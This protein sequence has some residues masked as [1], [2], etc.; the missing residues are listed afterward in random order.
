MC[1]ENKAPKRSLKMNPHIVSYKKTMMK[2]ARM[3]LPNWFSKGLIEGSK[4][5]ATKIIIILRQAKPTN[6]LF[7]ELTNPTSINK[8]KNKPMRPN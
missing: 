1:T 6:V 4:K 5:K 2:T 3:E 8:N 7:Y